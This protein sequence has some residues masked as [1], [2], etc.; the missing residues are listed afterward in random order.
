MDAEYNGV[1]TVIVRADAAV[2]AASPPATGDGAG[3]VP[4]FAAGAGTATALSFPAVTPGG[5]GGTEKKYWY[6]IRT[7]S[8][9][10]IA[11][12]I[13]F[14]MVPSFRKVGS[15]AAGLRLPCERDGT[16]LPAGSRP[17]PLGSSRSAG[18]TRSCTR[19]SWGG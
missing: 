16:G 14:S 12:I 10:A 7:A 1:F 5:G 13:R 6:P 8:D 2:F 17:A 19:S 18:S 4:P 3:T 15:V 9:I 11:R